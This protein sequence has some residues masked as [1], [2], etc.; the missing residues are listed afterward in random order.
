MTIA[1]RTAHAGDAEAVAA[2][3][4]RS[5]RES[6]RGEFSDAYLDGDLLGERLGVWRERLGSPAANQLVQ[7]AHDG[8]ELKKN[9][10]LLVGGAVTKEGRKYTLAASTLYVLGKGIAAKLLA[11]LLN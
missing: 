7:L 5:W 9:T 11:P 1:T 6:Y 4:T 2:L 8:A 10:L 3:H